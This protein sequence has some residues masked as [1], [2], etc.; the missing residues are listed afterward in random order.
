MK[1]AEDI[2][3]TGRSHAKAKRPAVELKKEKLRIE[4][5]LQDKLKTYAK[6][7]CRPICEA[8]LAELPRELRDFV[9]ESIITPDYIYVGPQYLTNT[10][11]PCDK[12]PGAFFWNPDYVG[13]EMR[14]ELV[15]TWYRTSLFYFWD[16]SKN[17]Q[18]IPRFM[19]FDRWELDLKPHEHLSRVRFDVG[20]GVF[21]NEASPPKQV[22]RQYAAALTAPF[23]TL[24][25]FQFP[26]RVKFLIR[27]QT[28]GSVRYARF[29]DGQFRE[30]L[31]E[32][33][34]DLEK[35]RSGDHRFHVEWAELD[36][37]EFTSKT[38]ELS[39]HSWNDRIQKVSLRVACSVIA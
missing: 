29:R 14:V 23:K 37:L 3:L 32:I 2:K 26:N 15:Q 4:A 19:T 12:D 22:S 30:M 17:S 36:N 25:Q 5:A 33:V 11:V 31:E 39:A 24:A 28:L 20:D 13:E 18:V 35:L 16:R 7:T 21:Y 8:V 1:T 38:G 6:T 34:E 9:Y 27:I 10:G